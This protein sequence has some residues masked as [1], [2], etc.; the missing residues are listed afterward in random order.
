MPEAN[1]LR[2]RR[3]VSTRWNSVL[4]MLEHFKRLEKY[5]KEVSQGIEIGNHH[6]NK[7]VG[8]DRDD[9]EGFKAFL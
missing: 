7:R 1:R 6:P 8:D 2:L 4:L 9:S 5:V 3:D